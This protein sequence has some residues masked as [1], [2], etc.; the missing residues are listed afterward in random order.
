MDIKEF[1]EMGN[2]LYHRLHLP[3][4][5]VAIKY[6]KSEDEIPEKAVRPSSGGQQW[7]LC[8]AITYARRWGWHSAMT[9]KDNFCVPS[10]ASHR[11]VNVSSEELLESQ[12]R[13][14]WRKDRAAE[15]RHFAY[16]AK[17]RYGAPDG[18]EMIEKMGQYVGCVFSPLTNTI[19]EPDSVIIYGDGGHLSHM[20][21]ALC[22]DYTEPVTSSFEGFGES[23]FKG[24]LLPFISGLPQVVIPGMG[25]RAFS[26][27]SETEIAL[28]IPGTAL[29]TMTE[30]LF[31]S[32]GKQN[33][34][35]PLK[36]LLAMGLTDSI[37][38]GFKY[39]REIVDSKAEINKNE[40]DN[41]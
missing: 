22:Y 16:M 30:H 19:I 10:S 36:P 4:F 34:G 12:V 11:W 6:I 29:Q 8:Q 33:M 40:E 5:P 31:K 23:C 41:R 1:Q 13:Q 25:D 2:D 27:T 35:L 17:S 3:T 7:S 24:C 9:E 15:E 38:P 18:A 20:I 28:G 21:Q 26:G 14:G 39:L 32:G 37:T